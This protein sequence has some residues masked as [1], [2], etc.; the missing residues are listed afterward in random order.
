[1]NLCERVEQTLQVK[2]IRR[3]ESGVDA[4]F[5]L[6][7]WVVDDGFGDGDW[8]VEVEVDGR[9]KECKRHGFVEKD[10]DRQHEHVLD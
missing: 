10:L 1:M 3:R 7:F 8:A 6:S 2:P 9:G 5:R 4:G